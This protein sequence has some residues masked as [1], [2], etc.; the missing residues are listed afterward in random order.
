MNTS[1]T[2]I[3]QIDGHEELDTIVKKLKQ[4][5]S[6]QVFFIIYAFDDSHIAN[7]IR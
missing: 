4:P 1:N 5:H 6:H 7:S 3:V 2:A